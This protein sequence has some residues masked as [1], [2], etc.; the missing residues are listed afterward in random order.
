MDIVN[1]LK[2]LQARAGEIAGDIDVDKHVEDARTA[3]KKVKEKIETDPNAR[4]AAL[5][6]GA[7]LMLLM[8]SKGGRKLVGNVAQTGA[9]AALG[10]LAYKAWRDRGGS[11]GGEVTTEE[12][13][14]AGFIADREADQDFSR[15]LVETMVAAAHADGEIDMEEMEIIDAAMKDA[16]FDITQIDKNASS[17]MVLNH[18]SAAARTPNHAA[19]LY[20]AAALATAN[21]SGQE[22]AFLKSLA[23]KLGLAPDHAARIRAEAAQDLDEDMS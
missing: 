15:A 3:A 22:T 10:A 21:P 7:L 11:N 19:Q 4:N 8:A 5:G 12:V 9:V 6:G 16:G 17:Q 1:L 14:A 13:A 18:I 20:A 2:D 23:D